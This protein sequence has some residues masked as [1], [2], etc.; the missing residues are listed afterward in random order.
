MGLGAAGVYSPSSPA[1]LS[2]SL[3]CGCPWLA[4]AAGDNGSDE[5]L[6]ISFVPKVPGW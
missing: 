2:V 4:H 6:R 3:Q 1:A 5:G